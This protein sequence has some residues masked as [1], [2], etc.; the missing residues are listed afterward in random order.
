MC[1]IKMLDAFSPSLNN[2]ICTQI[3][4]CYIQGWDFSKDPNGEASHFQ[5]LPLPLQWKVWSSLSSL[6]AS[7]VCWSMLW[8]RPGQSQKSLSVITDVIRDLSAGSSPL[9]SETEQPPSL[10]SCFCLD[11]SLWILSDEQ[12]ILQK[13]KRPAD[14]PLCLL[15]VEYL[16]RVEGYLEPFHGLIYSLSRISPVLHSVPQPHYWWCLF[17]LIASLTQ[18][19][20]WIQTC[21]KKGHG[22]KNTWNKWEKETGSCFFFF[23]LKTIP[24]AFRR[25]YGTFVLKKKNPEQI[26]PGCQTNS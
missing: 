16:L 25:K 3:S 5:H 2:Y 12:S 20:H 18:S 15:G 6:M 8:L 17:S 7:F 23:T 13:V 4:N 22:I 21:A 9:K 24:D 26:F 1:S 14:G 19:H 10:G 11:S